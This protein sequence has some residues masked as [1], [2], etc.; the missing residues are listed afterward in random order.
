MK[1]NLFHLVAVLVFTDAA[2][3]GGYT[4]IDLGEQFGG[5]WAINNSAQIVG[6]QAYRGDAL[7]PG[8]VGSNFR[9]GNVTQALTGPNGEQGFVG[10]ISNRG[11][12]VGSYRTSDDQFRA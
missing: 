10:G 11:E 3:Y 8:F 12:S 1:K 4:V 5:T 9:D 7:H 2:A 6:K